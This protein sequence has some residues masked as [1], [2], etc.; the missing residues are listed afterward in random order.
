MRQTIWALTQRDDIA[1]T[2]ISGRA[3]GDL[4]GLVGIPGL[5]YAGNHGMEISGPGLSF[6]EPGARAAMPELHAL[7]QEVARKLHHVPGAI[8]EDKGLTLSVHHRRV[9]AM[10]GEDVWRIVHGAVTP[11]RDRFHITLGNKVFEVRP[12]VRWNKGSALAWIKAQINK[13]D[14]AVI[15]IGDDTTDEDA[16]RA[17]GEDA[18]TIRVG[19]HAKTAAR[20]RLADPAA[21]QQFLQWIIDLRQGD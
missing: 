11:V 8:V 17:L 12:L 19:D 16:F 13:P 4:Q 18:V 9:A 21:V 3:H 2:V 14:T 7:A 10:D 1:V 20:H 6:L 5:I 15:Y